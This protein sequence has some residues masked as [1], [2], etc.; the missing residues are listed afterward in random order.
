MHSHYGYILQYSPLGPVGIVWK[1]GDKEAKIH[2]VYPPT[3]QP[4][5][6][7]RI[8]A[9]YPQATPYSCQ[10]ISSIA[11]RILRFLEGEA[12]LFDLDTTALDHCPPFQQRVLLAEA[13]IPRG[14]VSTYGRIAKHLGCPQGA[15]A[16]GSALAHNPFPIIIP[17]HRAIRSNGDLGGFQ[18]GREMKRIF[19]ERE[20][21]QLSLSG[22]VV[23]NRVY[24]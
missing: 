8:R 13:Q 1:P 22:K 16:V 6:A 23:M 24:Y 18:G 5:I 14:F 21:I 17:C 2:R 15:R 11:K 9:V 19:L 10:S 12:I 4:P 20:G 3:L 7:D